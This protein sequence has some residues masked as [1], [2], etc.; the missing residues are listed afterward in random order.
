MDYINLIPLAGVIALI[1]VFIKNSSVSKKEVG[2]A[3]MAK[4]AKNIADGA[5]AFLKAEYKI[6]SVFVI[7]TA[8]LLAFKGI[9]EGSSWLVA[10]SFVVG[11]LCSGLAGFIGMQ[12]ATKA[13]VR[14]R[15]SVV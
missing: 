8:V 10:V 11:A 14:D 9:N 7:I 5:M 1:F 13:N 6:L 3:K 15:K 4:I 12:V 2:N